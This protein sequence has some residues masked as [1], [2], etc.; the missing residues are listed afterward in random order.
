MT[1]STKRILISLLL[2]IA[3]VAVS[4]LA[5]NYN[6][7]TLS[8]SDAISVIKAAQVRSPIKTTDKN[9]DGVPDWQESLLVTE[10]VKLSAS[11]TSY[12]T[13]ETLTEQFAVDF[14]QDIVRAENYG[15]FGDTPEELVS[16]ASEALAGK[17]TDILL[18]V[19]D[20]N[21]QD[22][23]SIQALSH[24]GEEIARI[25]TLNRGDISDNEAVIL[26]RALRNQNAQELIVLDTKISA[27]ENI[28]KETLALA[29][30]STLQKEHVFLANSYQAILSDITAMRNAFVDPMLTL[31]RMKRYQ[32]DAQGL[33]V[34]LESIYTSLLNNGATWPQGSVVFTVIAIQ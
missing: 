8:A 24:Y 21:I 28:L 7:N 33:S 25:T 31:L 30:P 6:K 18:S 17:V 16:Q 19:Q 14:F 5:S 22:D 2:G 23:N 11:S 15:A 10:A 1:I 3:L 34:A 20:I 4:F 13:P 29:V 32:D 9:Q 27:Y 12:K 26:E